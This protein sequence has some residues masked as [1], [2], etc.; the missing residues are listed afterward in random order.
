ME[1]ADTDNGAGSADADGAVTS[2]TEAA[3]PTA[4]TVR[5]AGE[6]ANIAGATGAAKA[7]VE[8]VAAKI[9]GAEGRAG[10]VTGGTSCERAES[11]VRAV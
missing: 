9:V 4:G 7:G 11:S 8:G 10:G 1:E 6:E 3:E 2:T 5:M